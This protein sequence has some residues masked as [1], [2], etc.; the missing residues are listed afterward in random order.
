[1]KRILAIGTVVAAALLSGVPAHA[2]TRRN[3]Y[4][5]PK[6]FC[7]NGQISVCQAFGDS[8]DACGCNRWSQCFGGTRTPEPSFQPTPPSPSLQRPIP[9]NIQIPSTR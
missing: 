4:C 1:M 5:P 3:V 2:Q 6:P 7:T 9:P 8:N